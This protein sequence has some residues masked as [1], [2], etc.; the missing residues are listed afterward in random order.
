M[1]LV[2]SLQDTRTSLA[3]DQLYGA[4]KAKKKSK[5]KVTKMTFAS[6]ELE[7]IFNQYDEKTKNLILKGK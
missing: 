5:K 6:P 3:K 7:A 2:I 1:S 4:K